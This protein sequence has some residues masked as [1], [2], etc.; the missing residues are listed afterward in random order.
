MNDDDHAI[1]AAYGAEYRG[2]VQYY[3]L[4]GDVWQT[5]PAALGRRNLAA[6][7]TG[8]QAPLD[9]DEDGRQHNGTVIA[10]PTVPAG[11][12]RPAST[13]ARAGNH[14]SHGSAASPSNGSA[15]RSSPTASPGPGI[16]PRKELIRRLLAGRCELCGQAGHG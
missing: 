13:A 10:T 9:R 12:S 2:V 6:E 11:A 5:E 8:R 16:H 15:K 7:N 4:A 3:L 14:W 1:I